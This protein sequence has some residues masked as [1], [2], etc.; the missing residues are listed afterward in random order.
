MLRQ[1]Q[2]AT[3]GKTLVFINLREVLT[4]FSF[5]CLLQVACPVLSHARPQHTRI[6]TARTHTFAL[7]LCKRLQTVNL[8]PFV[9]LPVSLDSPLQPACSIL[10]VSDCHCQSDSWLTNG[11]LLGFP[12]FIMVSAS[13]RKTAAKKGRSPAKERRNQTRA[14]NAQALLSASNSPNKLETLRTT[15]YSHHLPTEEQRK[16]NGR[17]PGRNLIRWNRRFLS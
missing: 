13:P 4:Q 1:T 2:Q 3:F 7:F 14:Q 15:R 17:V 16:A 11:S 12:V 5:L 10:S 8:L 6:F 9:H